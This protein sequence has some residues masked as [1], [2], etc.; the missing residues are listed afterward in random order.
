MNHVAPLAASRE[1]VFVVLASFGRKMS[2]GGLSAVAAASGVIAL[3]AAALGHASWMLL[4]ACYV[5]WC[6]ACWGILFHSQT[7]RTLRWRAFEW[8]I[9]G[10][11]AA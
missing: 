9:V 11:A 3:A 10:S 5:V 2:Y 1:S 8:T 6:F 4:S 7:P